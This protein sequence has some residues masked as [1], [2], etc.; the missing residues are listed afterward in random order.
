LRTFRTAADRQAS[1]LE[2]LVAP[3]LRARN[4][5]RRQAGLRDLE[6][7]AEAAQE[8]SQLLFWRDVRE[9]AAR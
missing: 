8:L 1:L 9:F 3:A 7:L 4:P 2:A 6:A 5:E